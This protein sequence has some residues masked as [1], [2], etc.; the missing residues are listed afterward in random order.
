[1]R[2]TSPQPV[3]AWQS[4]SAIHLPSAWP[5]PGHGRNVSTAARL[6]P[7]ERFPMAEIVLEIVLG[8]LSAALA[9]LLVSALQRAG[10]RVARS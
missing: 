10:K 7:I 2:P 5:T 9:A 1:M 6:L 4:S 3:N 8:A